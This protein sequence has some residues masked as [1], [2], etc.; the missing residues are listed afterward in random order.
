MVNIKKQ[1]RKVSAKAKRD[2]A[3]ANLAE[4][5]LTIAAQVKAELQSEMGP[6][7]D[8]AKGVYEMVCAC[9]REYGKSPGDIVNARLRT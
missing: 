1:E 4:R 3:Q 6:F 7:T 2:A 8:D 5:R 9:Q